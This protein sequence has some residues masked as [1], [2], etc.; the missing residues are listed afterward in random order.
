MWND[1][2]AGVLVAEWQR[3]L[4]FA[5][6]ACNACFGPLNTH[7]TFDSKKAW[8]SAWLF[9]SCASS[10]EFLENLEELA[11]DRGILVSVGEASVNFFLSG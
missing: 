5:Y 11:H 7:A 1:I 2:R 4:P 10:Q 9:S 8:F 3:S 6:E